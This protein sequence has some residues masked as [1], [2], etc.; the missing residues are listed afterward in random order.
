MRPS[1]FPPELLYC[2]SRIP[3]VSAACL[4]DTKMVELSYVPHEFRCRDIPQ[5]AFVANR[6]IDSFTVYLGARP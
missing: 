4:K 6:L 2:F 3:I 1:F 5:W